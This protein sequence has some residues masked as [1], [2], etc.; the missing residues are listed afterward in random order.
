MTALVRSARKA[1]TSSSVGKTL[2]SKKAPQISKRDSYKRKTPRKP[3]AIKL[4]SLKSPSIFAPQEFFNSS[5]KI[6]QTKLGGLENLKNK[7]EEIRNKTISIGAP[8]KRKRRAKVKESPQ[9]EKLTKSMEEPN[10]KKPM[11]RS[12]FLEEKVFESLGKSLSKE[13]KKGFDFEASARLSKAGKF[14]KEAGSRAFDKS[15]S[16]NAST[17]SLDENKQLNEYKMTL[18][19]AFLAEK[20]EFPT[21]SDILALHKKQKS[22]YG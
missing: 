14:S 17:M 11:G 16:G 13:A 2:A 8:K 18:A 10:T 3:S 20:N 12:N 1:P 22:H 4:T 19:K 7:I 6:V 5:F 9:A 21:M 15:L